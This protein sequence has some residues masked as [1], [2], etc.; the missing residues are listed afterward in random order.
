MFKL[1]DFKNFA[2]VNGFNEFQKYVVVE[3][4]NAI[5]AKLKNEHYDNIPVLKRI[6]DE[7]YLAS[8]EKYTDD[9]NVIPSH[10]ASLKIEPVQFMW[11]TGCRDFFVGNVLKYISRLGKKDAD[12]DELKK[13]H[14]YFGCINNNNYEHSKKEFGTPQTLVFVGGGVAS[15]YAIC[16]GLKKNLFGNNKIIVIEKGK[17][18]AERGKDIVRGLFGGGA[19]SDNKNVFSTQS[20]QPIFRYINESNVYKTYDKIKWLINEFC[21]ETD[22]IHKTIPVQF[23][24]DYPYFGLN[25]KQSECWHIGS[26][27]GYKMCEKMYEYM[28]EKGV[29]FHTESTFIPSSTNFNNKTVAF[30]KGDELKEIKYDKLFV[31]LGRS[32]SKDIES[33]ISK[34][35]VV[36]VINDEIH[37]GFRFE[38]DYTPRIKEIAENIQYDF[39]FSKKLRNNKLKEIRTF[40][41]NHY[42]AE[43][44][45]E[46]VNGVSIDTREQ[47]NGHA[48]G[49]HSGKIT[50]TS[51]WA[52]LGTFKGVKPE[53]I[54][55][56]IE[57][58]TQG[59]VLEFNNDNWDT[60]RDFLDEKFD[61]FGKYLQYFINQ[62]CLEL[63]IEKWRILF[64][65]IKII[66]VKPK[67]NGNFQV[68]GFD[69][70][71]FY[72]DS[73]CTRGIIPAATT[74]IYSISN[75]F[76]G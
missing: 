11:E 12:K 71:Y 60:L 20:D 75:I 58:F 29:E 56:K 23:K 73:F 18:L 21:P 32:G 26:E 35:S 39:K 15:L 50:N 72:G 30:K 34:S 14:F 44:V 17:K 8:S 19:F 76:R 27:I 59:K 53:Q 74:S 13:I 4:C 7:Y 3:S 68:E 64:P 66:G 9:E 48:Y 28:V 61:D 36:D 41:A 40:C 6:T 67:V 37:F 31:A 16:Y 1:E 5:N 33:L 42:T 54:L 25:L 51:N 69:N 43:V 47:A 2:D 52:I 45:T 24:P 22:K 57:N 62:L 10:Y 38:C 46:K 65:E 55:S 70:V 63:G 49:L